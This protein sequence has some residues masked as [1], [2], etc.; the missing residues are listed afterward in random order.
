ML[1]DV[2]DFTSVTPY[3]QEASKPVVG[4]ETAV[5]EIRE[6]LAHIGVTAEAVPGRDFRHLPQCGA[7]F[8]HHPRDPH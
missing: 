5:R 1:N 4:T 2:V 6:L 7:G 8:R 3:V